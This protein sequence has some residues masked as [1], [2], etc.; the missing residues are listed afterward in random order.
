MND[1]KVPIIT[2]EER[3]HIA[4]HALSLYLRDAVRDDIAQFPST[5]YFSS[6]VQQAL[7]DW[8]EEKIKCATGIVVEKSTSRYDLIKKE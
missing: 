1:K 2:P 6:S 3:M 5:N 7:I 4:T 8:E